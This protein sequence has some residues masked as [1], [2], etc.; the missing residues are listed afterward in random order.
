MVRLQIEG[1]SGVNGE[2]NG[3]SKRTTDAKRN[4]KHCTGEER[5][6]TKY[7]IDRSVDEDEDG[8]R[9]RLWYRNDRR[10]IRVEKSTI[11]CIQKVPRME[12]LP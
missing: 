4:G 10:R 5:R 2:S 7:T 6:G 8:N 12:V 11:Q 9:G 3:R 1:E